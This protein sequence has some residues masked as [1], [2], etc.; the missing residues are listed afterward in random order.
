MKIE[1]T[2]DRILLYEE[3]QSME[4]IFH[5]LVLLELLQNFVSILTMKEN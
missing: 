5:M 1:E 4:A 3:F 2:V